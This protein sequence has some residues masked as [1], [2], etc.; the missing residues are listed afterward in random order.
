MLEP[1]HDVVRHIDY[2]NGEKLCQWRRATSPGH[3]KGS[4]VDGV[5]TASEKKKEKEKEKKKKKK[6][7]KKD[8][9]EGLGS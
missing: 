3:R 1:K 8:V 6:D 9:V 4:F 5:C 2:V 7:R